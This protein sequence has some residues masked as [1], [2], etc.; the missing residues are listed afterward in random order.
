[1]GTGRRR[2]TPSSRPSSRS[3]SPPSRTISLA[4]RE[5][6]RLLLATLRDITAS[7]EEYRLEARLLL[8]IDVE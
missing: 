2:H 3:R 6:R 5:F 1:M 7:D 4:R 8:G